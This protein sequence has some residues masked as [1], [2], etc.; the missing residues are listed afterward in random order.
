MLEIKNLEAGI[1]KKKII[2]GLS[3]EIG[4]GEIVALIGPNGSGK[5]TLAKIIAGYPGFWAKGKVLF[6]GKN[7]LELEPWERAKLGIFV[8]FQ[9]PPDIDGVRVKHLLPEPWPLE[10]VGLSKEFFERELIGLSGG[11]KKK[12]EIAQLISRPFKLAVLD[13]PDSGVDI[14]SLRQIGRALKEYYERVR[15]SMLVISHWMEIFRYIEPDRAYFIKSGKIICEG[16]LEEV[17]KVVSGDADG[18]N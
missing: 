17:K 13:E 16:S 15:P 9:F 5:S 8:A 6:N 2:D 10:K 18:C 11:E 12:L 14:G 1:G 4:E 7:L 3:L